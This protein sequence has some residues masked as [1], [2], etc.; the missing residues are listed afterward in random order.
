VP[1]DAKAYEGQHRQEWAA[2]IAAN[3]ARLLKTGPFF[4]TEKITDVYGSVLGAAGERHVRAAVKALHSDGVVANTGVG[5]TF[6]RELI[7]PAAT[8]L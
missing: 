3:I 2:T 8:Q 4:L 7:R 5:N 1:F 6:F